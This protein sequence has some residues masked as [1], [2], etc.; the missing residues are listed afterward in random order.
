MNMQASGTITQRYDNENNVV[1]EING[2]RYSD[3][4]GKNIPAQAQK[5]TVV[6]FPYIQKGQYLNVAG[7]VSMDAGQQASPMPGAAPA[8]AATGTAWAAGAVDARQRMII[9]QSCTT[10]AIEFC[11]AAG[12]PL[13]LGKVVQVARYFESYADGSLDAKELEEVLEEVTEPAN[14]HIGSDFADFDDD[15]PF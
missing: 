14:P 1:L 4:K 2:Q 7:P 10:R 6:S 5:G 13:K 15:I 3:Y 12:V 8:P 11:T 9:R